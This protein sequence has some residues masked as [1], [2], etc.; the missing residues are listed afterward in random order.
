MLL[1]SP[2]VTV[3]EMLYE[4]AFTEIRPLITPLEFH[5]RRVGSVEVTLHV[6]FPSPPVALSCPEYW[7]R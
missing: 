5:E 1:P 3:T 6:Y 7:A 4:P 2:S